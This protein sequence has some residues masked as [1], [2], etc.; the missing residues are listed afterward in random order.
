MR[1]V[2]MF[3][4]RV[5]YRRKQIEKKARTSGKPRRAYEN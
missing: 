5:C 3:K 1:E 2:Y 4:R